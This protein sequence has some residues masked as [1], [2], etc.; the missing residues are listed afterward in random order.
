MA[1]NMITQK[2]P[3]EIKAWRE[4]QRAARPLTPPQGS[5]APVYG[6]SQIVCPHCQV[7]GHVHCKTVKAKKGISGGK[8]TGALLTGGFSILATGLSRKQKV[9][10]AHCNNCQS[11]WQF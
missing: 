7:R 11:T 8:A 5:V 10:E 2:T 4:A 1:K 9:T 3:E 6:R